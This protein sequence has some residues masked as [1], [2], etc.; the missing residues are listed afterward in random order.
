[1]KDIEKRIKQESDVIESTLRS[2]LQSYLDFIHTLN[3][4][5][6]TK[7]RELIINSWYEW[8]GIFDGTMMELIDKVYVKLTDVELEYFFVI[9][10]EKAGVFARHARNQRGAMSIISKELDIR[11]MGRHTTMNKEEWQKVRCDK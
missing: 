7:F 1:M 3:E 9:A 2:K 8:A 11:R 6:I 4:T 10:E 5:E